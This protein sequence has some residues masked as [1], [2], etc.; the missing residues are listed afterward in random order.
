MDGEGGSKEDNEGGAGTY[1]LRGA[2]SDGEEEGHGKSKE[3]RKGDVEE[4]RERA[5]PEGGVGQAQD[6]AF[7]HWGACRGK[8]LFP[9]IGTGISSPKALVKPVCRR[10]SG[11]ICLPYDRG[12]MAEIEYTAALRHPLPFVYGTA[13]DVARWP[14]FWPSCRSAAWLERVGSGGT[15]ALDLGWGRLRRLALRGRVSFSPGRIR[16]DADAPVGLWFDLRLQDDGPGSL[17]ELSAAPGPGGRLAFVGSGA[18]W[19]RA[20]ADFLPALRQRLDDLAWSPAL[21]Q[22]RPEPSLLRMAR[23]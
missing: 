11:P 13:A 10:G 12:L 7:R 19:R 20:M 5:S 18:A 8:E 22:E 1:G 3:G 23:G 14:S 4:D 21:A 6:R 16:F 15:V 17:V 2:G 9:K